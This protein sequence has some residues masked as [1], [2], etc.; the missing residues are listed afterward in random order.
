MWGLPPPP[1]L[2][3]AASAPPSA[4][5]SSLTSAPAVVASDAFSVKKFSGEK[6]LGVEVVLW[7]SSGDGVGA[8]VEFVAD[9]VE[10]LLSS[11]SDWHE[12][13]GKKRATL[14]M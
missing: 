2:S 3:S 10:L 8:A 9:S 14:T 11:S 6:V 1:P 5:L 13:S 4:E 7:P 12:P